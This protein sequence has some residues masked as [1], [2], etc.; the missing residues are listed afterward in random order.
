MLCSL[1]F[2]FLFD[3]QEVL[4]VSF[5]ANLIPYNPTTRQVKDLQTSS[6]NL[7]HKY[8]RLFPVNACIVDIITVRWCI[9]KCFSPEDLLRYFFETFLW[10]TYKNL[11]YYRCFSQQLGLWKDSWSPNPQIP[12]SMSFLLPLVLYIHLDCSSSSVSLLSFGGYQ[13]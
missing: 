6:T 3:I 11:N 12:K 8:W 4:F 1:Q 2:L 7:T 5:G 13:P 9:P 10:K